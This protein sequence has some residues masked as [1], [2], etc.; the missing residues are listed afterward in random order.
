M[1][2]YKYIAKCDFFLGDL[3]VNEGDTV[4]LDRDIS[5]ALKE[6]RI[7]KI[8]INGVLIAS[9]RLWTE[10]KD[11]RECLERIDC[12]HDFNHGESGDT[13]SPPI[14]EGGTGVRVVDMDDISLHVNYPVVSPI[15]RKCVEIRLEPEIKQ[16]EIIRI[17][18]ELLK[19]YESMVLIKAAKHEN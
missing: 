11:L 10:T 14:G 17:D 4:H 1:K 9:D 13:E 16:G 6:I 12:R 8:C 2:A 19:V 7:D 5:K 15:D 18:G 3:F